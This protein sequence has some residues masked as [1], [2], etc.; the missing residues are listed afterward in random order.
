MRLRIGRIVLAAIA[1]EVFAVLVLVLLIATVGPRDAEGAQ[2]FAERLGYWVGPLAG[3]GFCALGG[4]WV[5]RGLASDHVANG[6]GLGVA[7]AAVDIGIL[8]LGGAA[9]QPI[10]VVS[11]LGRVAAGSLGGWFAGRT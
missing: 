3:F 9:F 10:F 11:N 6:F 4:A 1:T 8:V 7:A 2:V 5:A